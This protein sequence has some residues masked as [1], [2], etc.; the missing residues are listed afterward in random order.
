MVAQHAIHSR[1]I[2]AKMGRTLFIEEE[3]KDMKRRH[4]YNISQKGFND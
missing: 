4:L 3:S 2:T 1:K